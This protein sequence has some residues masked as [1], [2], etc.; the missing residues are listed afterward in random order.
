[1]KL[2]SFISYS[3]WSYI[4]AS[5]SCFL[6]ITFRAIMNPVS[7]SYAKNT[8]PNLPLPNFFPSLKSVILNSS[9]F[10]MIW[11]FITLLLKHLSLVTC[12]FLMLW[13]FISDFD[14]P[15]ASRFLAD[16]ADPSILIFGPTLLFFLS[17]FAFT[18]I[19]SLF[20]SL[21]LTEEAVLVVRKGCLWNFLGNCPW[22]S[23]SFD[24]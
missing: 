19:F 14:E 11:L 15:W 1:M 3:N 8:F 20:C 12:K 5:F 22:S 10:F 6:L 7:L 9:F 4:S 2:W 18:L 24:D 21:S 17:I 23:V 16:L 13:G